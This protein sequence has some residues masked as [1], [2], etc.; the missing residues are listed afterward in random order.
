M[1]YSKEEVGISKPLSDLSE[2]ISFEFNFA[3]IE[4]LYKRTK[5]LVNCLIVL[6]VVYLKREIPLFKKE[7]DIKNGKLELDIED[8]KLDNIKENELLNISKLQFDF[9]DPLTCECLD[10]KNLIIQIIQE[11]GR[12]LKHI[13]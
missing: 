8:F 6:D 13:I 5:V 1:S 7:V 2:K 11:K 3:K 12:I 9:V 10:T 4:A